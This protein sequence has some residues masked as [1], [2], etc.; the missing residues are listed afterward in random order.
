MYYCHSFWIFLL[1]LFKSTTT[2][3]RSRHSTDRPTVSEFHAE[4]LQASASEGLAQ[5]LYVAARAGF[6]PT[7]LRSR[8]IEST[9]ERP[10]PTHIVCL[11]CKA[12]IVK[13]KKPGCIS[14]DALGRSKDPSLLNL[15]IFTFCPKIHM[16]DNENHT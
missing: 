7:T 12:A 3:R 14:F 8:G 9:N 15:M 16:E 11:E 2:Q 5:G 13:H 4:V 1:H 6:E 10:R